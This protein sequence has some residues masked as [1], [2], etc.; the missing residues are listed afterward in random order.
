M[1]FRSETA[2]AKD[3]R[4]WEYIQSDL[5]AHISKLIS[6]VQTSAPS[7]LAR[8][9]ETLNSSSIVYFCKGIFAKRFSRI[10]M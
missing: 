10:F 2:S 5:F 9:A 3:G 8:R 1:V 7:K 4:W 6:M